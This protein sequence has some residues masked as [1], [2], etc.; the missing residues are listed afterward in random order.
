VAYTRDGDCARDSVGHQRLVARR[1]HRS[2]RRRC[3]DS[4]VELGTPETEGP[5]VPEDTPA[6]R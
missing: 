3:G 6:A 1:R 4:S 2:V 5:E